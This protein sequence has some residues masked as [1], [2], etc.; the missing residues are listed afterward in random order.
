METEET[1]KWSGKLKRKTETEN[2][3]GKLKA[4]AEKLKPGNG[5]QKPFAH[6]Q[7]LTTTLARGR[8]KMEQVCGS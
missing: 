4:E 3:N 2:W 6:A 1:E 7:S 8:E 5:R